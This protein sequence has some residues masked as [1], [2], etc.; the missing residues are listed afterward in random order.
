M[1]TRHTT[2]PV[3]ALALTLGCGGA[4][5]SSS[6][7]GVPEARSSLSRDTSPSVDADD[8]SSV[9]AGSNAFALELHRRLVEPGVNMMTSPYSVSTALAM[10][11]AGARGDTASQLAGALHFTLPGSR[12]HPAFNALDLAFQAPVSGCAVGSPFTLHVTNTAWAQQD[13]PFVPA[14]LDALAVNYGAGV[15]LLDFAHAPEDARQTINDAVARATDNRIEDLLPTGS[16]DVQTR[17]V[18][19]NAVYFNGKWARPFHP[20]ETAPGAFRLLDGS[21]V[22]VPF[23]HG[24][25]RTRGTVQPAYD[26]VELG[27]LCSDFAMTLVVPKAGTFAAFEGALDVAALGGVEAAMAD[28]MVTLSMPKFRF[29]WGTKSLKT[30]LE[31]LGMKD[32]FD[33][34]RADLTGIAH[35]PNEQLYVSD[36]AQQAFVAVD[37]EGTE[38]AAATA[39]VVGGGGS[40]PPPP[41]AEITVSVDRPFLFLIRHTTT[42]QILFLGRVVDP[43]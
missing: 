13:Y 15:S 16:I 14:Y 22:T 35:P 25:I 7:A 32:A 6:G 21:D 5:G 24:K 26:A 4:A 41:P 18:L 2:L 29:G 37:E 43:R 30:T 9:V 40:A 39:V 1:K 34:E 3:L 42:G 19:T 28:A 38:A 10:L 20:A 31:A 33:D 17:F 36:V 11:W 27:Y 8:V 23:M 12:L